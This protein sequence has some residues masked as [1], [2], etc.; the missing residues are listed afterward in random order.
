MPFACLGCGP[1]VIVNEGHRAAVLRHG[2]FVRMVPPGTYHRNVGVEKFIVKSIQ[3]QTAMIPQ[4][5]VITKDNVSVTLDAVCFY[6]VVDVKKAIFNV[7]DCDKAVRNLAQSTLETLLGEKTLAE[8]LTDRQELT[9]RVAELLDESC[10]SWG[11]HIEALEVRD[12]KMPEQMTRVMAIVA[13]AERE[14][15]AKVVSANAELRAAATYAKAA[16][17]MSQNPVALQLRYFQTLQEIAAE[18]NSTLIV[19][20]EITN[21]FRP[22]GNWNASEAF[23]K[24]LDMSGQGSHA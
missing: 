18:K 14:G 4:Q 23:Q 19:P 12:I 21:M 7:Q 9:H 8:L 22:L 20:S 10:M 13:E 24:S 17:V 1:V 6:R 3:I 11:V 16:D 2:K 15:E 5:R